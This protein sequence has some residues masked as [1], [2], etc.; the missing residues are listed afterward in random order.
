MDF[1][2]E[3]NRMEPNLRLKI[4]GTKQILWHE[5]VGT[6]QNLQCETAGKELNKQRET[7]GTE[8]IYVVK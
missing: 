2:Q 7:A 8:Q 5:I 4:F 3:T 6:E 1:S